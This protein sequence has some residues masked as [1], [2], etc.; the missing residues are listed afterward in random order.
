MSKTIDVD[1]YQISEDSFRILTA[2][3][4]GPVS[5]SDL[6]TAAGFD[7]YGSIKHYTEKKLVP[8]GLIELV[9]DD[10]KTYQ[11]TEKGQGFVED[12]DIEAATFDVVRQIARGAE[13]Q[14][15]TASDDVE[16][17]E[18]ELEDLQEDLTTRAGLQ[19]RV[20]EIYDQLYLD[21]DHELIKYHDD[22][23]PQWLASWLYGRRSTDNNRITRLEKQ[24]KPATDD[25]DRSLDARLTTVEEIA[26]GIAD[27]Q[28]SKYTQKEIVSAL[29]EQ[30]ERLEA[31]EEKQSELDNRVSSIEDSIE[32]INETLADLS[33]RLEEQS[34]WF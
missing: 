30:H 2:L 33:D 17:L 22:E 11:L 6:Q 14:A 5:A 31:V 3:R 13:E 12:Y 18:Q 10:P 21:A 20:E 19:E 8:A 9:G 32:D 34:G 4:D 23:N 15:A 28:S 27:G 1:G 24:V 7:H 26:H 25:Y 16:A 29:A